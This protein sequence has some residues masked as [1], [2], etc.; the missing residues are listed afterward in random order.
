MSETY[1]KINVM[2]FGAGQTGIIANQIFATNTNLKYKV[3]AFLEDDK[4]KVGNVI[5]GIRIF[6]AKSDF[7]M[8]VSKYQPKELILSVRDISFERKNE[9][10]DACLKSEIRIRSV[11]P[12]KNWVHGELSLGQIREVNIEDL[13]ERDAIKIGDEVVVE[14]MKDKVIFVSGA[15]GSIGSEL[16]RQLALY[17]PKALIL[18]D[19]AESPLF[20]IE[21]E[22]KDHYPGLDLRTYVADVTQ[23]DRMEIILSDCTPEVIFHAA[24]YKHV[25]MMESNP[26]EAVRCNILGTRILADLAVKFG[27]RKFVMIST[28]KAVN[29]TNV[30][31]CS[32]R[33]AEIYV[34]ALG[35]F[36]EGK[37]G[38]TAFVTTRFGNVLGSNGSVIPVF[39]K[40][41]RNGGPVKVT[42]PE[43][44]RF[45]MT[46]PEACRLVLEAAAMG[47]GSEIF[48]FDMGKPVKIYDL[49]KKMIRLSNLEQGK[50]IEI[51]FTGL[52]AGEKLHEEL[53]ND[54]ENT[55]PT[56]HQKILKAR[57]KEYSYTQ[58]A[59]MVG[60]FEDLLSDKNEIKLVALMKEIVP[61]FKSKVSQYEAL[62]H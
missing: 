62:D 31:G 61:E 55:I 6:D 21:M 52:R 4:R 44:T 12:I 46:I 60:L 22:L 45:F 23:K 10:I 15:A 7:D 18:V 43:I 41:I 26:S 17:S 1:E 19:Q 13:L 35:K 49:A 54:R 9:I 47:Q 58:I 30:M 3:V 51:V 11:P 25:P 36:A 50:D 24:A 27:V 59:S 32:K 5:S 37:S 29:P 20:E 34:Q 40:Q 8:L 38:S 56:H 2:I 42:H 16:C 53:L 39:T 28:D 48:I 33:I 14:L 57:T